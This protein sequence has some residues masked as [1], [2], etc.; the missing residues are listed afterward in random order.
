MV[1]PARI[2]FF[3]QIQ[4]PLPFPFLDLFFSDNGFLNP[5]EYFIV[6]EIKAPI[7]IIGL[8]NAI[9]RK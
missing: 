7:F 9:I 5:A 3:D 8:E 6:N 1:L 2:G 4:F